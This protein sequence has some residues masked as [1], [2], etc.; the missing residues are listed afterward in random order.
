M[1]FDDRRTSDIKKN[2]STFYARNTFYISMDMF[3]NWVEFTKSIFNGVSTYMDMRYY[4]NFL[5]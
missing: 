2:L 4:G 1:N 3:Q 5:I